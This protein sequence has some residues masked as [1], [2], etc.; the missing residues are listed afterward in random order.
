[1]YKPSAPDRVSRDLMQVV[2]KAPLCVTPT[3]S[4]EVGW[5][6]VDAAAQLRALP[7]LVLLDSSLP[8]GETGRYS[9]LTADPF[10]TLTSRGREI[11]ITSTR[12]RRTLTGNPWNVLQD[13][14]QRY[15][16]EPIPGLPPFQ[17]GVAGYFGY[18]LGR[19]L[20]RVPA[21]AVD[22]LRLPDI[23]VGFYDWV[24]SYDHELGRGWLVTTALAEGGLEKAVMRREQVLRL[25]NQRPREASG[26]GVRPETT[27]QTIM[28]SNIGRDAYMGAVRSAREYIGA[29]EIY[30]ANLS[31]RLEGI[32][33]GDPWSLYKRLRE[34][35][36]VPYGAYLSFGGLRV[37]SASPERFL[38]LD[39]RRVDTR[40]IKGTRPRGR[41]AEEDRNL[42]GRLRASEK[43]RAENLMIVDLLRNDLGR[44]CEVGSV[45]VPRLFGID[46][47]SH[48]WQMAST[49]VGD[50]RPGLDAVDLLRASF[51]GGSVT[52]C[53][54]IRSMEVIEELEPVRRGPYCGSIGYIG[55]SGS[56]DTSIVIRTLV[57]TGD[58]VYLQVGGA[59]VADSDPEGEYEETLAKARP[60][61]VALDAELQEW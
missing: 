46:G 47:Y 56:M 20:E 48:V 25:L 8:G 17:G 12:G 30:Q 44:V 57:L 51:P 2:E 3:L 13:L 29:G 1:M 19:H 7:G 5:T 37:L 58:R 15:G 6:P 49:A 50:L 55:F 53:P 60:G 18:D 39:G 21:T 32:W 26:R 10:L 52:G 24:L 31:H 16:Q 41:T 59:V 4:V 9:Y 28:R 33:Q 34:V 45:H 38:R 54:K 40:P 36:A 23:C 35:S 61:L 11:E 43:D 42:S 22:D 27:A 14:L